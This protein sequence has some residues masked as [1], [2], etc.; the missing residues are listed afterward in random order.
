MYNKSRDKVTAKPPVPLKS[1]TVN[2]LPSKPSDI[3]PAI[4]PRKESLNPKPSSLTKPNKSI[5]LSS[6]TSTKKIESASRKNLAK[7]KYLLEKAGWDRLPLNLLLD[8][9]EFCCDEP[10]E[11]YRLSLVCLTWRQLMECE[12]AV[13]FWRRFKKTE[14]ALSFGQFKKC[15]QG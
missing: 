3:L 12:N 15:L 10:F 1:T 13:Y 6:K 9:S 14:S 4:K 2:R 11:V 7:D 8:V 5:A